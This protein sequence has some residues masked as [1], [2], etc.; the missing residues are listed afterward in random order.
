MPNNKKPRPKCKGCDNNVTLLNRAYCS[1]TCYNKHRKSSAKGPMTCNYCSRIFLYEKNKGHLLNVCNSCAVKSSRH[2]L[3]Q[4]ALEYK[5]GVCM[6]CGY[7]RC[8]DALSFHHKDPKTK[9]FNV[10]SW[11]NLN[12]LKI[13]EELD[14]CDL[15][16]LNCHAEEHYKPSNFFQIDENMEPQPESWRRDHS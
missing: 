14:K 7:N 6:M 8:K 2:K 16:C 5:G 15:L 13:K 4:R 9:L 10:S 11:K 3:K 1:K 12:W